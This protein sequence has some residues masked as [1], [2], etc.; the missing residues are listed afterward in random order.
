MRYAELKPLAES[1]FSIAVVP[2]SWSVQRGVDALED[3]ERRE[4]DDE[5]RQLRPHDRV[6]VEEPDGGAEREHD[7]DR[8]PD[9]HVRV[10]REVCRAAGPELPIMTPAERSNSPPI[11]SSATGTATIPYCAAWSVQPA[12]FPGSPSQLTPAREV[13]E[14]EPDDDGADHRADVR[15]REQPRERADAGQPLVGRRRRLGW[16]C[17]DFG[18]RSSRRAGRAAR[19]PPARRVVVVLA[20]ALGRRASRSW[21]RSPR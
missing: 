8:R 11:I 19:A 2:V 6:A 17:C 12:A 16:C 15:A 7:R 20:R 10:R 3:E 5:A 4:R 14:R 13:A 1:M 21:P 9:V 18:H